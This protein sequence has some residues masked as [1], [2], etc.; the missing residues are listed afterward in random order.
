MDFLTQMKRRLLFNIPPLA[1][2]KAVSELIYNPRKWIESFGKNGMTMSKTESWYVPLSVVSYKNLLNILPEPEII[3]LE[4][5]QTNSPRTPPPSA[6]QVPVKL[7]FVVSVLGDNGLIT[8]LCV[9]FSQ[10]TKREVQIN[11]KT[12][13]PFM[14]LFL[15]LIPFG[16]L[17]ARWNLP[18][19]LG[20]TLSNGTV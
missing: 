14:A 6:D 16:P 9:G 20:A 18:R 19:L 4:S 3:P 15:M 17:E 2:P 8:E 13:N 1:T 10:E 11:K 5:A 7:K 12:I